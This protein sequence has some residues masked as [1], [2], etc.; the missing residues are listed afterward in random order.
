MPYYFSFPILW[1]MWA[2]ARNGQSKRSESSALAEA[3]YNN[4]F[5]F[6]KPLSKKKKKKKKRI[7]KKKK[8][9]KKKKNNF[10]LLFMDGVQLAQ[11]YSHFEEPLPLRSQKFLIL[12]WP[13]VTLTTLTLFRT[14][15]FRAAHVCG[16]KKAFFPD[17]SHTFYNDETWHSYTLPKE[18]PK[19]I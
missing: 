4:F 17:M 12:E 5:N 10:C 19:N 18:D 1:R 3:R 13:F 6:Q 15:I 2:F 11:G 8:K 14:S 7:K 16:G 9:K